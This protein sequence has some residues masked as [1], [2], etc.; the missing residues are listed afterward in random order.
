MT[1]NQLTR[2]RLRLR[3]R[4]EG[5]QSKVGEI[6]N[7]LLQIA[8]AR[9]AVL[10]DSLDQA[11]DAMDMNTRLELHDHSLRSKVQTQQALEKINNGTF[12]QCESCE[13]YI[14]MRRLEAHPTAALCL[15]CQDKQERENSFRPRLLTSFRYSDLMYLNSGAV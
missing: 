10:G 2:F 9:P 5:I 4:L 3:S 1:A 11:K 15:E 12:G 8:E 7:D 6:R 14:D 13:E